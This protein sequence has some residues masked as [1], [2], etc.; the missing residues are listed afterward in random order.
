MS[1]ITK[2]KIRMEASPNPQEGGK[3]LWE[4]EHPYYCNEGNYYAPGRDQPH[5]HYGRLADF[6]QAEESADL[7]MNLV[8]RWDWHEGGFGGS[9]FTGDENYRNGQFAVFIMGQRKGLYRWVTVDVCRADE[10][11]V[12]AYLEPRWRHMQALWA[13]LLQATGGENGR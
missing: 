5:Q 10:A 9:E 11:A 13:P 4:V 12:I 2:E 7:D 3:R 6:L 8:F 1:K